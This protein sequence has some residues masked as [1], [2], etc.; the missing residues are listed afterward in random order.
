MRDFNR[1]YPVKITKKLVFNVIISLLLVYFVFHTIYGNR[2]LLAYFKVNQKLDKSYE[3]LK[4]LRSE[5]IEH[6][7]KVKL[8]KEGD[9]DLIDEKARNI[10]GVANPNE[11]VFTN[12]PKVNKQ[13]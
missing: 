3:E 11:Q 1:Y 13:E 4:T 10:L 8:L 5:R 7:H 6:E 2:G 12:E 9:K